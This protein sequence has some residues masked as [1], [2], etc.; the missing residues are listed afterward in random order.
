[1]SAK[2]VFG[3][4]ISLARTPPL[5][6]DRI[7]LIGIEL[8]GAWATR[9]PGFMHDGSVSIPP[10]TLGI[11]WYVGELPL[12]PMPPQCWQGPLHKYYPMDVNNSCGMHVHLSF[13]T[14]RIYQQLMDKSYPA[15]LLAY[16]ARWGRQQELP[17]SH[18]LWARLRGTVSYCG[19]TFS[20]DLQAQAPNKSGPR[21]AAVNYCHRLHGTLEIRVLPMMANADLAIAAISEV[22]RITNTYLLATIVRDRTYRAEAVMES[23]E[24]R[25][26]IDECVSF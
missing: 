17:R 16:L 1:M 15:T 12:P 6:K 5:R 18:P 14:A 2:E 11:S 20:P 19:H 7:H 25:E 3:K 24:Y 22:L 21:Y 26:E 23:D 9:P 4:A 13:K 8:E 10:P